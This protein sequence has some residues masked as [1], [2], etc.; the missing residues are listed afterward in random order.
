[1]GRALGAGA[2]SG[3]CGGKPGLSPK[4]LL[5]PVHLF[6]ARLRGALKAGRGNPERILFS[7]P[8][9]RPGL[10]EAPFSTPGLRAWWSRSDGEEGAS[11]GRGSGVP[12]CPVCGQEGDLGLCP[13]QGWVP[14][15]LWGLEGLRHPPL[16]RPRGPLNSAQPWGLGG[17]W[18]PLR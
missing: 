8:F 9:W 14:S 7:I 6:F 3:P 5:P 12:I 4:Q 13:R 1:M 11:R 2:G 17:A 10:E 15:S 18:V 16:H